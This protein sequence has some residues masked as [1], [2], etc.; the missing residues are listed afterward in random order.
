MTQALVKN[1]GEEAHHK[2]GPSKLNYY[3]SCPLFLNVN[4][5]VNEAAEE[6]DMLHECMEELGHI[7]YDG[8]M[9][10]TFVAA[11]KRV[12]GKWILED[13]QLGYLFYTCAE[14]DKIMAQIPIS[15]MAME[16][17]VYL[18]RADGSTIHWGTL[19]LALVSEEFGMVVVIDY[20]FGWIPVPP[21]E[22]NLQGRSYGCATLQE[23]APDI[24][25][26]AVVF[27]QPKLSNVTHKTFHYDE[28]PRLVHQIDC[29]LADV[30]KAFADPDTAL[31]KMNAGS[32]C[33]FCERCG[34]CSVHARMMAE[35]APAH[36][37]EKVNPKALFNT[38]LLKTPEQLVTARYMV[39]VLEK[40]FEGIKAKMND[41]LKTEGDDK[42]YASLPDGTLLHYKKFTRKMSRTLGNAG[43]VAEALKEFVTWE[44]MMECAK[45]SLEKLMPTAARSYQ[46]LL[47]ARGEKITLKKAREDVT[48]LLTVQG[49]LSQPDGMIEFAKL[50]KTQPQIE[51]KS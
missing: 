27:I 12:H 9:K 15:E 26:A 3:A 11:L 36:L 34:Q 42:T 4:R 41:H 47:K 5:E 23:I 16:E 49:L 24:Q 35:L 14:I 22:R 18:K 6:G 20:K 48:N 43:E 51:A 2:H 40:A 33:A 38:A 46:E 32:H 8:G 19:D 13:E 29:L 31:P 44:Q 45:L 50:V 17:K 39:D 21:A 30:D 1:S 7:V 28:V 25:T 10:E 37:P